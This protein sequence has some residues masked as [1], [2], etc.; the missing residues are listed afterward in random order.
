MKSTVR[1]R[2]FPI[3]TLAAMLSTSCATVHRAF[4]TNVSA[5]PSQGKMIEASA[6]KFVFLGFNFNND[7]AFEAQKKLVS[8]CPNG[9]VTGILTTFETQWYVFFTNY[10]IKARGLCVHPKHAGS[11][12]SN[13]SDRFALDK[14]AAQMY[15]FREFAWRTDFRPCIM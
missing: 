7:Y 15:A 9:M 4:M 14:G 5:S 1:F 11:A 13:S 6:E 8:S 2:L 3:L 12:S 10:E